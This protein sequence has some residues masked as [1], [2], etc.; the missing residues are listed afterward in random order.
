LSG[1][2][3]GLADSGY[4]PWVIRARDRLG[5]ELGRFPALSGWLERAAERPSIAAELELVAAQR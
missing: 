4:L 3:F 5:V 1:P 2:A